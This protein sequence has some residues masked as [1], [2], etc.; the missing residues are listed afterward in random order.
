MPF[1]SVA[2][3]HYMFAKHPQVA[4][5]F[6]S[7]TPKGAKLPVYAKKKPKVTDDEETGEPRSD[8]EKAEA[9]MRI[10]RGLGARP[11]R[12]AGGMGR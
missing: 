1:K 2:Q 12:R 8:D 3:E 6:A 7:K 9:P 11:R 10:A 5:E 4:K